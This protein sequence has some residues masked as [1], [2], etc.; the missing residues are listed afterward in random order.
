MNFQYMKINKSDNI[1]RFPEFELYF[2]SNES[3]LLHYYEPELGLFVVESPM[4]IERALA[5]GYEPVSFV[6]IDSLAD[7]MCKRFDTLIHT[8]EEAY[9]NSN[10][11]N[12]P[13]YL[14]DYDTLAEMTGVNI[15]RGV[16]S[17]MKRKMLPDMSELLKD[18][19]RIAVFDDVEN[20]TNVGAMFRS[21]AALGIE[22]VL[23]AGSSSDPLYRR[24]SRV[25]VGTVFSI[26]WTKTGKRITDSEYIN[27]LHS[28]GFKT[29]AMAL[30]DN[31]VSIRDERLKKEEKLAIILGNEGFGLSDTVISESDY[32]VKIPMKH[33]VDSLNVAAASSIVFWELMS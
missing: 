23:L 21:A 14:A 15:T 17:L 6:M 27:T 26:P 32:V 4:V 28:L 30:S 12:I 5:A 8:S 2:S 10:S 18:Y 25:S 22:A 9:N 19:K 11:K 24:A 7:E 20:P 3:Q 33:N 13:V 16:L 1:P 29:A 31:S